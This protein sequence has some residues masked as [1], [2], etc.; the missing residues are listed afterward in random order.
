VL[1]RRD[2]RIARRAVWLSAMVLGAASMSGCPMRDCS[3]SSELDAGL[4]ESAR[5]SASE[6]RSE[7]VTQTLEEAAR[8]VRTR[9][10]SEQG[11]EWRG[12][13]VEQGTEVRA[14]PM[15]AWSCHVVVGVGSAALRELDVRVYDADGAEV[16]RDAEQGVIAALRFCPAQNGTYYVTARAV[17]GSGLFA[18]RSMRGPTGLAFHVDDVMRAIAPMPPERDPE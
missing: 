8:V 13:L 14:L 17:A 5:S 7:R 10:F 4:A 6:F 1:G 2:D 11:E 3:A 16:A 12:F 18:L 15:R 9:G